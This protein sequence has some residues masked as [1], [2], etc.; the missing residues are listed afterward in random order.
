MAESSF[1]LELCSIVTNIPTKY[2]GK[3]SEEV[4]YV[5]LILI[6]GKEN[7][8]WA[9]IPGNQVADGY[10]QVYPRVALSS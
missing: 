5:G 4:G 6:P 8:I 9:I 2:K 1:M 3:P 7:G 10:D